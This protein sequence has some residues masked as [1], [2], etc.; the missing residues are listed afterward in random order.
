MKLKRFIKLLGLILT[1]LSLTFCTKE[2]GPE[3]ENNQFIQLDNPGGIPDRLLMVNQSIPL[4][5]LKTGTELPDEEY[6][7]TQ[8]Y[9]LNGPVVMGSSVQATHIKYHNSKIY[10][11]YNTAGSV[12]N[13]GFDIIDLRNINSPEVFA[14]GIEGTEYNSIDITM[15]PATAESKMLLAGTSNNLFGYNSPLIQ[16]FD[17]DITGLP[18][19]DPVNF[20]LNG[21]TATD[22]NYMGVV[23]GTDGG[24]YQLGL[25][26]QNNANYVM[27]LEDARSIAYN[28]YNGQYIALLGKPGRLITNLSG[29]GSTI[30]LGG[31]SH[32]GTKAI[33]R[34]DNN[35]AYAALGDGGLKIVDLA[36]ETVT[37]SL[38]RPPVPPGENNL[39]YVTN[40]ISINQNG[41]VFIANGAAGIFVAK[42]E[43]NGDLSVLGYLDMDASVNYVESHGDMIFAACGE[44]GVAIIQ[45][46][47]ISDGI[48][49]VTTSP[50]NSVNIG[51]TTA[52]GGGNI[53]LNNSL[54]I[55]SRGVCWST[56]QNP[57][58]YDNKTISGTGEGIFSSLMTGLNPNT[59]YYVRAYVTTSSGTLYGNEVGFVSLPAGASSQTF[60]DERDGNTYKWVQIGNQIWMAQNLAWLPEVSPSGS[61]SLIAPF[62]Y[63]YDYNG[64]DVTEAKSTNNY[65]KYGVLYNWEAA[66]VSCPSGWHLP[67]DEEWQIMEQYLGMSNQDLDSDRFRNSGE[68]ADKL[69]LS[70][71]WKF[72]G[73]NPLSVGFNAKPAGYR[74]RGGSY[75]Y[76]GDYTAYWTNSQNNYHAIYRGIYHFN[77]GI[78]RN[79]FYKSGGF[80]VRCI[81]D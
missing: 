61:G 36:T 62:Y 74:S 63:V 60:K 51:E 3:S 30:N 5:G 16:I 58:I 4:R 20:E 54:D 73:Q 12:T 22:V 56:E 37:S 40:G 44:K 68:I 7:F 33:V 23:T 78:Y 71:A 1:V 39:N 64:F 11:T 46:T 8:K 25:G 47:G 26:G 6:I 15:D 76:D 70:S 79:Y 42:R 48:P 72:S 69:R 49:T 27:D 65:D 55:I 43:S 34:V 50:I 14:T 41:H 80:S 10:I 67:T 81:K 75:K 31:I 38:P 52:V 21:Y 77:N 9:L 53:I 29:N 17:L 28:S 66:K 24:F 13:G 18:V 45:M 32:S 19:L 35:Y 2:L 59:T 57:T